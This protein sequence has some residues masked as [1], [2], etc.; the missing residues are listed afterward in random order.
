MTDPTSLDLDSHPLRL[1]FWNFSLNEL[2]G[3]LRLRNLHSMHF[4]RHIFLSP[5][6][7]RKTRLEGTTGKIGIE[8]CLIEMLDSCS[9]MERAG[10]PRHRSQNPSDEGESAGSDRIKSFGV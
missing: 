9:R 2:K 6:S 3:S 10:K 1:W 5:S 7:F 4:C 8:L